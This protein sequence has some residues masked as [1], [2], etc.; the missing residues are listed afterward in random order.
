M[1]IRKKVI[2]VAA[3][4]A[5]TLSGLVA[6]ATPASAQVITS[7]G[8]H[9]MLP[10]TLANDLNCT[11]TQYGLHI[12]GNSGSGVLDLQGHTIDGNGE[13]NNTRNEYVGIHIEGARNVI[14]QNGTVT[15]FDAGVAITK[16]S[17][18]QVV[19]VT[20]HDN[21]NHSTLNSSPEAESNRCRFG[22]GIVVTNSNNNVIKNSRAFRNGPFDGIGLVGNSDNNI[23]SRN[24]VYDQ[25]VA[26]E[27]SNGD[28]GP[29]GP[30]SAGPTGAGRLYQDIGIRVEGPGANGNQVLA[31]N[32]TDNQLNGISIH[33]Y[34]CFVGN[35]G[36]S[37]P[38]APAVGMPSTNNLIQG[39]NVRRNGF[40]PDGA[41]IDG[42]GILR[43]G[44]FGNITCAS[45][46]NSIIANTS[47]YNARDGIF[48]PPTGD[49]A[50]AA[51]NTI[52]KNIVR[53]N[54]RDGIRVEGP[55]TG[56]LGQYPGSN[57][58][59]LRNNQGTGNGEHDGHDGNPNCDANF[60]QQNIFGTVNQACVRANGGSGVVTP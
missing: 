12:A 41:V 1:G 52:D 53:N 3:A 58:N 39:N 17:R 6:M 37:P 15:G 13:L 48:V 34:V 50:I 55:F 59:T 38:G 26:N 32:V 18:N 2:G 16:G 49:P 60:W 33:G 23:V 40:Q 54:R 31:N 9:V 47:V 36:T 43:Q 10:A 35:G 22:D 46:S 5:L 14:V 8:T 30:F 57:N 19:N 27:L 21:V 44:P 7:C 4:S 42:I 28:N 45:N 29:C 25:N 20:V 11:G 24:S 51:N 56:I